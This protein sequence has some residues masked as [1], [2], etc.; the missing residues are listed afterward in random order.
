MIIICETSGLQ[1]K[2]QSNEFYSIKEG[3]KIKIK[4]TP[5]HTCREIKLDSR[6]PCELCN[7]S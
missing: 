7:H 6:A 5:A 4:N 2:P 3:P 1:L